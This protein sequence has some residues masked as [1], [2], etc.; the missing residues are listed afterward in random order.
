MI[1]NKYQEKIEKIPLSKRAAV[2]ISVIGGC[3]AVVE[4]FN[5]E[6]AQFYVGTYLALTAMFT[7]A[8]KNPDMDNRLLRHI[9]ADLSQYV[10]IF[11]IAVGRCMDLLFGVLGVRKSAIYVSGRAIIILLVSLLMAEAIYHCKR[12]ITRLM[13][14]SVRTREA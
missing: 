3:L 4:R 8:V 1:L 14:G 13:E 11:H 7:A 12:K 10:Y 9:G 2:T 5:F 6:E